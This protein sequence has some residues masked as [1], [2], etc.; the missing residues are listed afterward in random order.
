M[1]SSKTPGMCQLTCYSPTYVKVV[2]GEGMPD[3]CNPNQKG[4]LFIDFDIVFPDKLTR[5]ERV[6]LEAALF[7]NGEPLKVLT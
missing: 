4:D 7:R 3:S 5:K 2:K 1:S 6:D